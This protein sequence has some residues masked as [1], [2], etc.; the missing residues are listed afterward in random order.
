MSAYAGSEI[1]PGLSTGLPMGAPLP[2]G[3]W[4]IT[5]PS[6]GSR[7]SNPGV[8][9]GA[10]A[11]AWLI[12]STP[13]KLAGGVIMLDATIPFVNV[14]VENGPELSGM[15]NAIID[16]QVKWDLGNG[17]FGGFQS[18]IYLPIRSDVGRNFV[19][20]QGLAALSY[21]RDGW[22]LSSTFYYGTGASGADGGPAWSNVDLTATKKFGKFEIGA[23]GFGSTDLSTPYPGY[24]KQSQFALGG[25]IGYDFDIVN[26]QLKL[27]RDVYQENYGGYETRVWANIIVPLMAP[28]SV[29]RPAVFKY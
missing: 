6:Y 13:Y 18:G 24:Q 15:A 7:D 16:M 19:S 12:W 9:V 21:L 28:S 17:F 8:D 2:E 5:F 3:L 1:L 25:L 10:I 11:P 14:N 23:V 20:W 27:T 29:G 22:N 26:V 4:S